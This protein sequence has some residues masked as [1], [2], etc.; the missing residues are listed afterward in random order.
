MPSLVGW[1]SNFPRLKR[2]L[3]WIIPAALVVAVVFIL[4]CFYCPKPS[5]AEL[6]EQV[7]EWWRGLSWSDVFWV[8][9]GFFLGLIPGAILLTYAHFKASTR[10]FRNTPEEVAA[11]AAQLVDKKR[12][13][14][15]SARK[16]ALEARLAEERARLQRDAA[17]AAAADAK[18]KAASAD[19]AGKFETDALQAEASYNVAQL[20]FWDAE[21]AVALAERAY[22]DAVQA[23]E[24]AKK[25]VVKAETARTGDR[26]WPDQT[27]P[28]LARQ[29]SAQ[30]EQT[31]LVAVARGKTA[32]GAADQAE[33]E[34][35][36][37]EAKVLAA[38]G[39]GTGTGQPTE[40]DKLASAKRTAAQDARARAD[41]AKDAAAEA[42]KKA[43]DRAGDWRATLL[44]PKGL[45]Q[46]T[47]Q[48]IGKIRDDEL[49]GFTRL[50]F[51]LVITCWTTFAVC[52]SGSLSFVP[53]NSN[54]DVA[55]KLSAAG[56]YLYVMILLGRRSFQRD[57]TP[58][59]VL[60]CCVTM[61]VGPVLAL[62]LAYLWIPDGG[63]IWG[64]LN[65]KAIFFFAGVAPRHVTAFLLELL[66]R[67]I[68]AATGRP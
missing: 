61:V 40:A 29:E 4:W 14:L 10:Y 33:K 27:P 53:S 42:V 26:R 12:E 1:L 20:R 52:W 41:T 19:V 57:I 43:A 24:D 44:N 28:W 9:A 48:K 68:L 21:N 59:S 30:A 56:A 60:W 45:Q 51:I 6:D 54:G 38:S 18:K 65:E 34:A 17:N 11:E 7:R 46:T 62:V 58:S 32:M 23:A 25:A 66:R 64:S 47:L 15:S 8:L 50:A 55:L 39:T 49:S 16:S 5:C 22:Y 35:R 2:N 36:A 3:S 63:F 37:A 67:A 13:A 31:A